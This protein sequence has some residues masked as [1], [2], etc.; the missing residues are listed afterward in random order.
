MLA[1]RGSAA[2]LLRRAAGH[3]AM[4]AATGFATITAVAKAVAFAKEAVVASAFGVGTSMDSY[5]MAL[6]VISFPCGVLL[7]A[8]QTVFV[9]DYVHVLEVRGEGAASR[10]LRVAFAG[11]LL[12][13]TA[14]LVVWL[15]CLPAILAVV[16]H[17]LPGSQ[18]AL[19]SAN[20]WRLIPY[21]YLNG[22]NLL[23]Y[24][25]LQ[26]RKSFLR[27]ALIPIATPL[28]VMAVVALRGADLRVLI[29]SLTVGTG[30][31]TLLVLLLIIRAQVASRAAEPG[32]WSES[33]RLALG[34]LV[35]A[36]G[37]LVSGLSP[38][39]EQ[40]IASGL[41]HGAISALGYAAKLPATLNTLLTT[42]VGVTSLP[43]FAQR[44]ALGD[45]ES[46]RRFFLRYAGLLAVVGLAI[47]AAAVLGS[48]PFVRLAFQRGHFTATDTLT[49]TA[50]QQ[51]YLW[52]LPG[53]LVAMVA[54]RYVAAQGRFRTITAGTMMMVPLT[55]LL[56]WGLAR[57]W[58]P[59]GLA[60]GLSTGSALTAATFV[61]LALSRR[62]A[63]AR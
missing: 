27:S 17:G 3:P 58:G 1:L 4:R 62:A 35:L 46:C 26:A 52:Q 47:A 10:F 41:G 13:L 33:R 49:V 18:R 44:L 59:F 24:G 7:N 2:A 14:L 6:V 23:G 45:L 56:Q 50:L 53:A 25:V 16:G 8:A 20:V 42:A 34:T 11:L 48:E 51:A 40:T 12:C 21:Y 39:I 9:R 54:T 63:A 28:V 61:C 19:V 43:Y 29:G 55:G 60:L 57:A 32:V 30:V 15:L 22:I 5:L 36:A 31:E 38:V 37:T